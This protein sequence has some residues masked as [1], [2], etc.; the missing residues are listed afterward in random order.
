M[1]EVTGQPDFESLETIAPERAPDPPRL[2]PVTK[3]ARI[4]E[5]DTR[6]L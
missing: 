5:M 6:L 2:E 3:A 4:A 1:D